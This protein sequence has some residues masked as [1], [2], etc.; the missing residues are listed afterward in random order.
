MG[1]IESWIGKNVAV[2]LRLGIFTTRTFPYVKLIGADSTGIVIELP[3]GPM[4]IPV[5]SIVHVSLP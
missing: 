5:R 3:N 1:L 4:F 2:H